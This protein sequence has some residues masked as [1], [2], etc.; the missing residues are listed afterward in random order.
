MHKHNI[1]KL[2][3]AGLVLVSV[4]LMTSCAQEDSRTVTLQ[5]QTFGTTYSIK[6]LAH[7]HSPEPETIHQ[8]I[9]Q[10]L[11]E[12]DNIMSTWNANSEITKLNATPINTQLRISEELL[13]LLAI[14][15]EIYHASHKT[16]DISVGP[17]VNIWKE[18]AETNIPTDDEIAAAKNQIGLDYLELD[19]ET[20]S[21]I[22]RR[23]LDLT[24]AAIGKGYGVDEIG[25]VIAGFGILDYLVEIGGEILASGSRGTKG[26]NA[27]HQEHQGWRVAIEQPDEL[28]R[29][30]FE[31]FILRDQ[32][33]ATSGDYRNYYEKDGVRYSHIIDPRTAK[34]V[35]HRLASVSV[36][37]SSTTYADAWA[38][39]LFVLGENEGLQLAN[40]V[41]IAAYFIS[42]SDAGFVVTQS[43]EFLVI[44]SD[45]PSKSQATSND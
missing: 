39:A 15:D 23:N 43:D 32:A 25:K 24:V 17:L 3:L 4:V 28:V 34:P 1:T 41:G 40:E 44:N 19:V 36:V 14:S 27:K 11:I 20:N 45:N 6:Y 31:L 29:N 30:S 5:G 33:M 12:I 42:R 21:V 38:T 16:F 22:K 37:H 9:K 35:T 18:S 7:P 2:L 10:R 13:E 26:E 8:A